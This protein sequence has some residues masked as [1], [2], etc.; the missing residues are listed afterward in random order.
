[1][2][3]PLSGGFVHQ[4]PFPKENGRISTG[5]ARISHDGLKVG[6]LCEQR[7]AAAVGMVLGFFRLYVTAGATYIYDGDGRRVE[8]GFKGTSVKS[9]DEPQSIFRTLE[10]VS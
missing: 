4:F 9:F 2:K 10:P 7:Q 1:M 5:P 6:A 8:G 3:C